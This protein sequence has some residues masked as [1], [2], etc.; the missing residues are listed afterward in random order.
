MRFHPIAV[1]VAGV[2]L[3]AGCEPYGRRPVVSLDQAR[4][5]TA[6]FQ[7]Q[8]FQ[9]PPLRPPHPRSPPG[10]FQRRTG[11]ALDAT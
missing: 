6:Q 1:A 5:I 3:L 8:G 2:A 11:R 9:P 10:R 7:G 4:Q